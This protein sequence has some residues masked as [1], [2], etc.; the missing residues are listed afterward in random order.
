MER[1][2]FV[3]YT[4]SRQEKKV[5]ELLQRRGYESFLPLHAQVRQ[6]SDRK[7]KV[8]VPL[9]N[10]YI[11]VHV[12]EHEVNAVVQ[13]PGVAW[14][15][16]HNNKPAVLH[17]NELA[18]IKRFIETGWLIEAQALDQQFELGDQVKVIDGPLKGM[19]GRL[20]HLANAARLGVLLESIGHVITVEIDRNAVRKLAEKEIDKSM[21]LSN[22]D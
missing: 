11:F 18:T 21:I 9:F 7:K 1:K 5:D 20:T 17:A 8:Q 16:R 4:K 19:F 12:F 14:S 15:I 13:I 3:F 2:W 6:W 22:R 10:S